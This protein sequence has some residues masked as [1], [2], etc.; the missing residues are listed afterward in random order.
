MIPSSVGFSRRR[1]VA[2]A[3][4]LVAASA[5][6]AR[7]QS[8]AVDG[9][10]AVGLALAVEK[11]KV[12]ALELVNTAIARLEAAN[13]SI[14]AVTSTC[15]DLARE[16]AA[17]ASGSMGGVPTLIKDN[18]PQ[19]G[20]VY[21]Q[22]SRAYRHR[23]ADETS[24]EME[25]IERSGFIS[26][27]RTTLPEFGLSPTTEAQL[28]G[29]TRNPWNLSRS[30]GGSSGG[31]AAVV[32]AGVVPVAYGNDGAGSIRI[33]AAACG[34]VGLKH[35]RRPPTSGPTQIRALSVN[36]CLS[37]TVRD[38]AAWIAAV[39]GTEPTRPA[40]TGPLR[41]RTNIQPPAGGDVDPAVATA[42]DL[43]VKV[44]EKLGHRVERQL[45]PYD[46]PAFVEAF[47]RR[48]E[49]G[50]ATSVTEFETRAGRSATEADLEPYTLGLARRGVNYAA[51]QMERDEATI[52]GA[53]ETFL[54]AF[55]GGEIYMTPVL[56]STA[57]PI[58]Q[59]GPL[60]EY[61]AQRSDLITYATFSWIHSAAGAPSI[62]LPVGQGPDGM[63]I[64]LQFGASPGRED[65]LLQL[66]Y[67][68]ERELDWASRRP[69][70]WVGGLSA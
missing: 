3:S 39:S 55:P 46:G 19:I 62:S 17:K 59:F 49:A 1:F 35:T 51:D 15:F 18:R 12:T 66:A 57:V 21:T 54:D 52:R 32:A 24:A 31:S 27:G 16:A 53:R 13:P 63:P 44:L 56:A 41:I 30:V 20:Q 45:L 67:D 36:S 4:A 34:L 33:P 29:P 14:N 6:P 64:G 5:W 70:L 2:A 10:D 47:K 65:L 50:A 69:P 61:E 23:I 38:T 42:F 58:G 40:A 7:A 68:L 43:T 37:R 48:Y 25:A 9:V 11:R 8:P 22:G 26:I 60:V 28:S